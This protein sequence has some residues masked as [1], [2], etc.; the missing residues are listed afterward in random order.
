[1]DPDRPAQPT[2]AA[3]HTDAAASAD[4]A[5][6]TVVQR[7]PDSGGSGPLTDGSAGSD[8]APA[9]STEVLD[10][11]AASAGAT[12]VLR[13]PQP[14]AGATEVIS[15][16]RI[17]PHIQAHLQA[18]NP[19]QQPGQ[20][21]APMPPPAAAPQ[22][23]NAGFRAA[24]P[25]S[26]FAPAAPPPAFAQQ[27]PNSQWWPAEGGAG[28][29]APQQPAGAPPFGQQPYPTQLQPPVPPGGAP[30]GVEQPRRRGRLI[31]LIVAG[32]VLLA[33]AGVGA[34]LLL[35]P[36]YVDPALA[37]AEVVAATQKTDELAAT[38]VT[39]PDDAVQEQGGTFTCTATV[40]GRKISYTVSQSDDT[41][42]AFTVRYDRP[43]LDPAAVADQIVSSTRT[44]FG[45]A[46]TDVQCPKDVHFDKNA[47]FTCTAKLDNQ[48]LNY[49]LTQTDGLGAVSV[50]HGRVLKMAELSAQVGG[51]LTKG[52]GVPVV[53]ECGTP[54]QT[55]L[56]NEPDTR[57]ECRA[58]ATASPGR[59]VPI[60]IK[61]DRSGTAYLAD[62][63]Q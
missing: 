5:E 63:V 29:G 18:Q 62:P 12:E 54:G 13:K 3:E 46:P 47:T 34:W 32:V 43:V 28:H 25:N 33:A 41:G 26:G 48:G 42:K 6:A 59:V 61:V 27:P 50:A 7:R 21:P 57:I 45:V 58:W 1:M 9:A 52:A 39:C 22:G 55:L 40:V 17:P 14:A 30:G 36:R 8:P 2:G 35:R 4:V 49:V 24:A 19:V 10:K 60:P 23:G 53:A 11:P 31:A 20:R 16:P 51:E 38:D 56:V 37:K 44:E 15:A